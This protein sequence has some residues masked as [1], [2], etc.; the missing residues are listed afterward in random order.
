[1]AA[2]PRLLFI[3]PDGGQERRVREAC[4]ELLEETRLRMLVTTAAH[5]EAETPFGCIWRQILPILS[6]EEQSKRRALWENK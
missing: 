5:M 6:E 1:M 3:V 4:M 2:L